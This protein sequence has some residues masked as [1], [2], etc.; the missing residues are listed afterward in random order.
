MGT[1]RWLLM[2]DFRTSRGIVLPLVVALAFTA[3]MPNPAPAAKCTVCNLRLTSRT[4]PYLIKLAKEPTNA[5]AGAP[6]IRVTIVNKSPRPLV[7]DSSPPS[8]QVMLNFVTPGIRG[9]EVVHALRTGQSEK[10]AP[11]SNLTFHVTYPYRLGKP[12]T[13]SVN[14]SY[15][16]VDSNILTYIVR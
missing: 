16:S 1:S 5:A 15:G 2:R 13:Y 7:L 8:P 3:V 11:G 9:T 10:I 6:Y 4:G 12:G 14:V